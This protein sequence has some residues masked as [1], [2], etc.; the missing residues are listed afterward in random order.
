MR[1]SVTF[2]AD[3]YT[4]IVKHLFQDP[5][6]E[7][8]AYLLCGTSESD[9]ETR[10]LV[11]DVLPV[12]ES[13]IL[14]SSTVHMKI[15]SPSF[16]RALKRAHESRQCFI[17]VHSHPVDVQGH[18]RQ[19]D[20]E[21]RKLFSTAYNRIRGR[22]VHG[23]FVFSAPDNPVGRIWLDGGVVRPVEVVSVI[24]D[25]LRFFYQNVAAVTDLNI[26]DRQVR[27]FGPDLQIL[28][29]RLRI[30]VVGAGGTGSSIVEQLVRLGVGNI[31]VAD[32]QCLVASNV[33]RVYGSRLADAG[34]PKT[35]LADRLGMEIGLGTVI[36]PL[37]RAIT[38]ESV[39]KNF[40]NCDLIFGC[41]DDQWGRSLLNRLSIYYLI[42]VFD[43]AAK[44]DSANG[45]IRSVQG[46][47]TTLMPGAACLFCRGRIHPD[48]IRAEVVDAVNP[49]E[50]ERLRHDGYAPELEGPDPA[51]VTFTTSVAAAAI[52]QMLHRLTGFMGADANSTEFIYRFDANHIGKNR[53]PSKDDCFCAD[54]KKWGR[55]DQ[56]LFLETTWR[57][58]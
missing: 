25:R 52:N 46:R 5:R 29:K 50:A 39:L 31:L 14:E 47:V 6:C 51:V 12:D 10:L 22:G 28:L 23:S 48:R 4:S 58:E 32:P 38:F 45:I 30:G 44:I 8:A 53:T 7:R 35:A 17:F 54:R 42:P 16:L 27:A 56:D 24:G 49:D 34:T 26:Y 20:N 15:G 40:R 13:E 11:Q 37:T 18:S 2:L 36:T 19:D 57:S 41:T 55:G 3:H 33:T 21:E 1:Y 43:M 9:V